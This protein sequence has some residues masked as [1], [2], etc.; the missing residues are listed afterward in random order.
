VSGDARSNN[1]TADAQQYP[2]TRAGSAHRTESGTAEDGTI[3]NGAGPEIRWVGEQ[4]RMQGYC[5]RATFTDQAE[6]DG[7]DGRRRTGAPAP[8]TVVLLQ[9]PHRPVVRIGPKP[10]A[11]DQESTARAA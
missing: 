9:R 5:G 8:R 2:P 1:Q 7:P 6:A 11:Q 10:P 3:E 4:W